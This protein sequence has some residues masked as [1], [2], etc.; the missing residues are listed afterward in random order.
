[1]S[2]IK[3][4]TS[5]FARV[6]IG[7]DATN[8]VEDLKGR[9]ASI[10]GSVDKLSVSLTYPRVDGKLGIAA[11]IV[12]IGVGF[13]KPGISLTEGVGLTPTET[14]DI[15]KRGFDYSKQ[16]INQVSSSYKIPTPKIKAPK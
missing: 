3:K 10:S 1:M 7:A 8:T 11:P 4:G 15:L 13:G 2:T 6:V 12:E 16:L 9:G 14:G 5:G